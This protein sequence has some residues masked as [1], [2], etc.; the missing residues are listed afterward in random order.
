METEPINKITNEQKDQ[1]LQTSKSSRQIFFSFYKQN[2]NKNEK[3]FQRLHLILVHIN[4]F[5]LQHLNLFSNDN[6]VPPKEGHKMK[7]PSQAPSSK[8]YYSGTI[9]NRPIGIFSGGFSIIYASLVR[10]RYCGTRDEWIP[11]FYIR[12]LGYHGYLNIMD[13]WIVGYHGQLDIMDSWIMDSLSIG[14]QILLDT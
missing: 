4:C 1:A 9:C 2:N 10:C 12:I 3:K 8:F 11:L 5:S 13:T 7:Y 14:I 6:T